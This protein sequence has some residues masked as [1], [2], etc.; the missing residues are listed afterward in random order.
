MP[1]G[2]G[3]LT[4]LRQLAFFAVGC[5]G[6]DAGISELKNLDMSKAEEK[7]AT[8]IAHEHGVLSAL[9]PPSQIEILKIQGYRG[10]CLPIWLMEHNDSAYFD[11]K[12]LKQCSPCQ[13]LYLTV[14]T[15]QQLPNLTHMR[16][17][18]KF[19]TL[20]FLHLW[21]MA[22]LEELWTTTSGFEIRQEDSRA[23]NCF[24]VLYKLYVLDCPK[25]TTVKPYF[26]PS[27]EELC[28]D[29]TNGQLLSP[30]VAITPIASL[31]QS[32]G[33][34]TSLTSL[35]IGGMNNLKLLTDEIQQ[36][37]SLE[38]LC[39]EYCEALTVLPECIGNL[40]AL[41][42]LY[43][44]HCSALQCLPQSIQSSTSLQSLV[45]LECPAL[46]SRYKQAVGL[47][48]DWQLISH[49]PRVDIS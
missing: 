7:L 39:L 12:T 34:L 37:I 15:L 45:I 13:F 36:L 10:P 31:P 49:I 2:F 3:Q 4:R 44:H 18:L 24:P 5:D 23:Q 42:R 28:L 30:A 6:D 16:E 41:R 43:I 32:I 26:P 9:E 1:S 38:F 33:H 47:G 29:E 17:L 35:K 11:A 40:P 8:D 20:K 25:F 27:L 22:N 19:P 48:P 46:A 14:L 21:K